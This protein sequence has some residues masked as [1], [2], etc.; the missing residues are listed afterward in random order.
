MKNDDG[1][2]IDES[3]WYQVYFFATVGVNLK[4]VS[5]ADL[6]NWFMPIQRNLNIPYCKAFA[7]FEL[8]MY[9][10]HLFVVSGHRVETHSRKARILGDVLVQSAGCAS[11]QP[12]YAC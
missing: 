11:N 9:D 10:F 8:G 7:R 5:I 3:G 4:S 12:P 6:L 1:K 2:W